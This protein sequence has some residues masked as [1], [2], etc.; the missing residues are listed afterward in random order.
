MYQDF[1]ANDARITTIGSM[2]NCLGSAPLGKLL[3]MIEN[4]SLSPAAVVTYPERLAAELNDPVLART[5]FSATVPRKR[6]RKVPSTPPIGRASS[7]A[8]AYL[9]LLMYVRSC[10]VASAVTISFRERPEPSVRTSASGLTPAS[11]KKVLTISSP[12]SS[13]A[14]GWLEEAGG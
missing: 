1:A 12:A 10:T 6:V 11:F 8:L 7:K 4:T 13:E 14:C 5:L 9:C 2:Q 3:T